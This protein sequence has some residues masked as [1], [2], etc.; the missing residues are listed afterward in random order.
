MGGYFFILEGFNNKSLTSEYPTYVPLQI[1]LTPHDFLKSK[2][3]HFNFGSG[4]FRRPGPSQP[5]PI[6]APCQWGPH[7]PDVA[8]ESMYNIAKKESGHHDDV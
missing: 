6:G 5:T 4:A 8:A 1:T 2:T 7:R 3:L